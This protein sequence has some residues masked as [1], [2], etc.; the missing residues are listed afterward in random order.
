MEE[1]VP[2]IKG[3]NKKYGPMKDLEESLGKAISQRI[4]NRDIMGIGLPI[5]AVAGS[6]AGAA[7]AGGM[8]AAVGTGVGLVLGIIDT[9]TVKAALAIMIDRMQKAGKIV[10]GRKTEILNKLNKLMTPEIMSGA[11][12]AG[13]AERVLEQE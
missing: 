6:G 4:I 7:M 1:I 13:R 12:Q 9:P 8:G 3:L 2:E 10:P 5:K 11:F